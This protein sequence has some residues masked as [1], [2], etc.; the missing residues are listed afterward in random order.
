MSAPGRPTPGMAFPHRRVPA[1]TCPIL[2][3]PLRASGSG[4]RWITSARAQHACTTWLFVREHRSCAPCPRRCGMRRVWACTPQ[5]PPATRSAR[6]RT[7]CTHLPAP[8]ASAADRGITMHSCRAA[9]RRILMHSAHSHVYTAQGA[10]TSARGFRQPGRARSRG[11][12]A[13]PG[14]APAACGGARLATALSAMYACSPT[15]DPGPSAVPRC[16]P[17]RLRRA[18]ACVP[19]KSRLAAERRRRA[20][21]WAGSLCLRAFMPH[22]ACRAACCACSRATGLR[23]R[24]RAAVCL[25]VH[26]LIMLEARQSVVGSALHRRFRRADPALCSACAPYDNNSMARMPSS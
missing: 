26:Q 25:S 9:A 21:I 8:R 10:P 16:P 1:R 3:A 23:T 17:A 6:G 20:R 11:P 12:R 2:S 13:H 4:A 5:H 15:Q 19:C 18:C 14:T 24:S 22:L 7:S